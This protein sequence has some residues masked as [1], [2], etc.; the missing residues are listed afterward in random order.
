MHIVRYMYLVLSLVNFYAS[1]IVP[2]FNALMGFTSEKCTV[3]SPLPLTLSFLLRVF[4][5]RR[6]SVD[7][8][9]W[10]IPK[11]L[12]AIWHKACLT[13]IRARF[14]LKYQENLTECAHTRRWT[15]AIKFS[16]TFRGASC[17]RYAM[18]MF[19]CLIN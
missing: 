1:G 18:T 11:Q 4:I 12:I 16:W 13:N 14:M 5:P 7:I 9:R 17:K 6:Y 19:N 10:F 15:R 8:G 3:N 2:R